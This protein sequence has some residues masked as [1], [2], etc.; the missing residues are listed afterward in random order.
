M[1]EIEALTSE[2]LYPPVEGKRVTRIHADCAAEFT[3]RVA[4][5]FARRRGLTAT[6]TGTHSFQSNGRAEVLIRVVKNLARRCLVGSKM[7]M[8]VWSFAVQQACEMLRCRKLRL[9]GDTKVPRCWPFGT[10]VTF[11]VPGKSKAFG[12]FEMKGQLGRLLWQDVGSRLC[13]AV[14]PKGDMVKGFALVPVLFQEEPVG[15]GDAQ[16]E[17]L[18]TAGWRRVAL[19]DGGTAWLHEEDGVLSLVCPCVMDVAKTVVFPARIA[20]ADVASVEAATQVSCQ[21]QEEFH[22]CLKQVHFREPEVE[23][24]VHFE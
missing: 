5:T 17:E 2:A 4:E 11:R 7:P 24:L 3:G 18:K 1:R 8:E 23:E 16:L 14:D 10:Y 22:E 9:A 19:K 12:S 6:W 13:Y 15:M 20:D 21:G